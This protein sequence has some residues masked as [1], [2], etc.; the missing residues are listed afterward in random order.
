[1]TKAKPTKSLGKPRSVAGWFHPN[2]KAQSS[3]TRAWRK[4]KRNE[5][6]DS[7]TS[8]PSSPIGAIPS[9][10]APKQLICSNAPTKPTKSTKQ[11]RQKRA[12][13]PMKAKPKTTKPRALEKQVWSKQ[14]RHK[15]TATGST[16]QKQP[17]EGN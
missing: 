11:S 4:L 16:Q 12:T 14:A 2:P 7:I 8:L 5:R 17:G 15:A 13:K 6:A 3:A 9:S 10:N 1:M